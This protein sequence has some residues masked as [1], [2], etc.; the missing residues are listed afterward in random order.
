LGFRNRLL[1]PINRKVIAVVRHEEGGGGGGG[2][3]TAIANRPYLQNNMRFAEGNAQLGIPLFTQPENE[4]LV[5][6]GH[7][8]QI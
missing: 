4:R 6:K 2:A 8:A 5:N 1:L 3:L 7:F